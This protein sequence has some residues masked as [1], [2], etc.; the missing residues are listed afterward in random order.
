MKMWKKCRRNGKKFVVHNTE[1]RPNLQGRKTAAELASLGIKV[2]HF[3]DS[4]ARLAL[5][6][7]DIMLIGCD[8]LTSEGKIVNKIGSELFCEAA[9]RMQVPVYVCCTSWKFDLKTLFGYEE[10]IEKRGAS[11]VWNNPPRNVV[12]DNHAFERVDPRLVTG[13][14]T[15]LGVFHPMTINEELRRCAWLS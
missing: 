14:I 1:T 3:V 10:T 8:A 13:L 11:E 15:E 12:I 5:K 2:V 9:S 4:A 6:K 7:A